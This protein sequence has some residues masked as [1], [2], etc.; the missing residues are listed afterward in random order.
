MVSEIRRGGDS[1]GAAERRQ[2]SAEAVREAR[3]LLD[4]TTNRSAEAL[5]A[6]AHRLNRIETALREHGEDFSGVFVVLSLVVGTYCLLRGEHT[7]SDSASRERGEVLQR[8]RWVDRHGEPADLLVVQAR[9]ML[10]FLLA[11]WALPRADGSHTVLRDALLTAGQG[12]DLLTESLRRDLTEAKEVAD[13]IAAAP[14]DAEFRQSTANVRHVIE[15]ML[16]P[17]LV[18]MDLPEPAAPAVE[19]AGPGTAAA[20]QD[21]AGT[22]DREEALLDAVRG[23]VTLARVRSTARYTRVLVWLIATLESG[24]GHSRDAVM[25]P[26]REAVALLRRAGA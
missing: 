23:L 12:S 8:L 18:G 1:A 13:R 7:P 15:R 17:G 2:E 25:E 14:L 16:N 19:A 22:E 20:G 11:P 26:D 6:V 9:M 10:V 5:I 3:R 21:G 4:D 24:D